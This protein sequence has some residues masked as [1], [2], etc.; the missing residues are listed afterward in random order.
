M[1]IGRSAPVGTENAIQ[2]NSVMNS[3][4]VGGDDRAGPL[5]SELIAA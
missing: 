5:E 2:F 3:V 1:A 4:L